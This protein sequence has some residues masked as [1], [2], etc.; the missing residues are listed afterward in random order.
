DHQTD[1][2]GQVFF[3]ESA[4]QYCVAVTTTNLAT[5]ERIEHPATCIAHSEMVPGERWPADDAQEHLAQCTGQPRHFDENGPLTPPAS[6]I[7]DDPG[8]EV[9]CQAVSGSSATGLLPFVLLLGALVAMRRRRR[10]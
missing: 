2:S 1:H 3:E 4:D 6:N 10:A 7:H 5:G 9:G 8:E